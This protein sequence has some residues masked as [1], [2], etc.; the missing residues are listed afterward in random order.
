MF[1]RPA[2]VL[3]NHAEKDTPQNN[4]FSGAAPLL[5]SVASK[6]RLQVLKKRIIAPSP[7]KPLSASVFTKRLCACGIGIKYVSESKVSPFDA[8]HSVSFAS[9]IS[10]KFPF[11]TPKSGLA[12]HAAIPRAHILSRYAS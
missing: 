12:L 11:P 7:I 9:E 10:M 6:P 1:A 4:K 5:G 3:I 8:S 2:A